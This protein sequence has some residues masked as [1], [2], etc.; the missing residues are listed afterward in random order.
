MPWFRCTLA[1]W[2][3]SAQVLRYPG[4]L[5]PAHR[6]T[7]AAVS[8]MTTIVVAAGKGGCG[9][10][11]LSVHLAVLANARTAPA[12]LVD[13]DPQ[14]SAA[15]WRKRRGATDP[16]RFTQAT[17]GELSAVQA[18]ARADGVRVLVV[19]T[20]PRTDLVALA[21]RADFVLIPCRPGILDLDAIGETVKTVAATKVSA[22]IVFNACPAGRGTKEAGI[23]VEAREALAGSPVPVAPVSIGNRASFA[24]ALIT[25]QA[26]SEFEPGGK[27][28]REL[29]T[30]WDWIGGRLCR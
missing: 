21:R 29:E 7:V 11:T 27:G 8:K 15:A 4:G 28:A 23:V 13:T 18:R 20:A 14:S 9:K 26:V 17:V 2:Y 24:H 12:A 6:D 1:P 25:G 5:A 10:S 30:L 19:D 3:Q 16:L 22:G